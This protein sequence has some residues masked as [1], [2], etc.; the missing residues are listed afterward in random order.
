MSNLTIQDVFNNVKDCGDHPV[1]VSEEILKG[2]KTIVAMGCCCC[3]GFNN[4]YKT[5]GGY[6][7]TESFG[8]G[9]TRE[10]KF[11]VAYE[12]SDSTGHG[13]RCYGAVQIFDSLEDALNLGLDESCRESAKKELNKPDKDKGGCSEN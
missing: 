1:G 8:I 3:L 5:C 2:I 12:N 13:C 4:E 10:G 11:L 7:D 6:C 9:K